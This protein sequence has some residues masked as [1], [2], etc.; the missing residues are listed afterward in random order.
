MVGIV[1]YGA[2]IPKYRIKVDEIARVWNKDPESIKK[3]LLV[4]EKAVPSLDE[5]TAT[6]AVEASRN[7]LK[8]AE[9]DPRDIGAVYVG[10]ESHPYAVKPTATIV[11]EAIDATPDLTAAD[12]EFACKA[13]TAG[14]QMCMGLVESGL[15]NYGL[16]VGADT[17]QGAPGDALEYTAAA[18]GAAYIIGKS[19][20]IAEFN[21]TYSFTTDT[22]DF[23]RRE[24]KPY[25][26]HGGRF[27]GEPAYFKHVINAAKG[28]MEK[29]GTKPEDYDYCVFHQPNG[30]FYIRVAKIL[31]FK[32]EQYKIG[33]LTPYI[34]NTYSG[35][36]PLGLSNV[37]DNCEGG[38]RILA[39]SYGSGAGSD[40]FDITVTNRIKDVKDK[41]QRTS[42]YIERKEYI[43]YA[44]YAK[45]RKKI[46][47]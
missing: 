36:V 46:R 33:L 5:D 39:V 22:P 13:G 15:I 34:G 19:K 16:A 40:A 11:A 31:G 21:G 14:I 17:A 28:L 30:K 4:Y 41:A 32:E 45:F 8:R 25:P 7:A 9:I 47:M 3:G 10:S 23:W 42:Y 18:G 20:V 24:G 6:I 1:G 12:L 26:R 2:Y 35:A 44:I 29:M 37:L 27:T 43:D 38:E